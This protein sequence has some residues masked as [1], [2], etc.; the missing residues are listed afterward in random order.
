MT[1]EKYI[2]S[3]QRDTYMI[4]IINAVQNVIFGDNMTDD[5]MEEILIKKRQRLLDNLKEDM[6]NSNTDYYSLRPENFIEWLKTIF[7]MI[8][9]R[10]TKQVKTQFEEIQKISS[11]VV[12][13]MIYP[14]FADYYGSCPICFGDMW[15]KD[16]VFTKCHHIFHETCINE[17]LHNDN[18]S[19]PVCRSC[20]DGKGSF[21]TSLYF[22]WDCIEISEIN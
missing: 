11:T 16:S 13:F 5:E 1:K 15:N 21:L 6:Q 22:E 8:T 19:C 4:D 12:D 18:N 20:L 3:N 2:A 10:Y 9:L 14:N 17:W 7:N